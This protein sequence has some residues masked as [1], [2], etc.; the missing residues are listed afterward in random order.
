MK[1]N[2]KPWQVLA[3]LALPGA[4]LTAA[5]IAAV[6]VSETTG[7]LPDWLVNCSLVALPIFTSL[8]I[9]L[10]ILSVRRLSNRPNT[11]Q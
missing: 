3:L 7:T 1:R 11:K 9:G 8:T 2:I 10:I 4:S 6:A 5:V